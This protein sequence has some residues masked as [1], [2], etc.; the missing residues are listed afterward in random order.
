MSKS[1]GSGNGT[2]NGLSRYRTPRLPR[3][4][5]ARVAVAA[6]SDVKCVVRYLNGEKVRSTTKAR[7]ERALAACGYEHL[8]APSS[9]AVKP[10]SSPPP[11]SSR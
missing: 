7:V 5:I 10:P 8:V 1:N 3:Q 2:T 11:A 6:E 9:L 4:E